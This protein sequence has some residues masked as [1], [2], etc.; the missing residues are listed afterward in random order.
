MPRNWS[1]SVPEGND[2]VPQQKEFGPDQPTLV[3][4]HQLNLVKSHFINK[5]KRLA[6]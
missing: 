1:K 5:R 4:V 6:N 3:D 2:P